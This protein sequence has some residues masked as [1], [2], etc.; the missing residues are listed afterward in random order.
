MAVN[1]AMDN[2]WVDKPMYDEAERKYFEKLSSVSKNNE[3]NY[4]FKHIL[5]F[6]KH[7]LGCFICNFQF[8]IDEY[9]FF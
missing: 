3:E 5:E 6:L 9:V 1:Y 8:L 4:F 7:V 2:F